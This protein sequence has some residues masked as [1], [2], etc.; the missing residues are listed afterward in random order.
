MK[1]ETVYDRPDFSDRKNLSVYRAIRFFCLDCTCG[2][3]PVVA[4]CPD[5]GCALWRFRFGKNPAVAERDGK[6][7]RSLRGGT[8]PRMSTN[9]RGVHENLLETTN[10]TQGIGRYGFEYIGSK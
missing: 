5:Y 1:N 10:R 3:S 6:D 2:Q 8:P 4:L 9:G 7:V